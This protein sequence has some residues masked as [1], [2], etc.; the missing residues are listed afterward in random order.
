[1]KHEIRI[2]SSVDFEMRC[3]RCHTKMR[4]GSAFD[5]AC[6]CGGLIEACPPGKAKPRGMPFK[7]EAKC[8]T[9]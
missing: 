7:G 8:A 6:K 5:G 3:N 4:G 9:K 1:M 2:K